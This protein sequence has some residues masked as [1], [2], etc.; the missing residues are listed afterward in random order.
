MTSRIIIGILIGLFL[1][2]IASKVFAK[3]LNC[4]D[5]GTWTEANEEYERHTKDIYHLDVDGDNVPCEGLLT[6]T[7]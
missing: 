7:N 5:F 2:Y 1:L 6:K 3:D 4:T